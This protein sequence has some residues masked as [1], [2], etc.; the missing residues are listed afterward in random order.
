MHVQRLY[1]CR[2][3]G[4]SLPIVLR[5]YPAI[6]SDGAPYFAADDNRRAYGD[7]GAGSE[8]DEIENEE[9]RDCRGDPYPSSAGCFFS[10]RHAWVRP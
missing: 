10:N 6:G 1:K 5:L 8:M 4:M 2:K 7:A 9:D 3:G